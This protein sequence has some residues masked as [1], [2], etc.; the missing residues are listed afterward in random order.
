MNILKLS[1]IGYAALFAGTVIIAF[2]SCVSQPD[3]STEV[4]EEQNE[5]RFDDKDAED[6]ASYLADAATMLQENAR[7]GELASV[8]ATSKEVKALGSKMATAHAADLAALQSLA[9]E[10][11][12][13]LPA[14][15][16]E[17]TMD[18]H[19][20]LNELT[21]PE[22]D[23]QYCDKVVSSHKDAIAQLEFIEKNAQDTQILAWATKMLPKFRLHLS[24]AEALQN[25][26][27]GKQ[28]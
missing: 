4:A 13:S 14:A 22:F 12:I 5:V 25:S 18:A 21:G 16:S 11:S 20:E 7:W 8:N 23:K 28:E 24:T 27:K 6:D 10:K 1:G 26:L 17:N 15:P 19:D 3:D 2:T 9:T